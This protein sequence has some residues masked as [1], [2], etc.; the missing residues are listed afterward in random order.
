MPP[1]WPTLLL[2]AFEKNKRS[3]SRRCFVC[4]ITEHN[5]VSLA[6]SWLAQRA[7]VAFE[8]IDSS[9]I[10]RGAE[11]FLRDPGRRGFRCCSY[12]V[13]S[14]K[15]CSHVCA[16]VPGHVKSLQL[17]GDSPSQWASENQNNGIRKAGAKKCTSGPKAAQPI[18]DSRYS[19]YSTPQ[20]LPKQRRN[21]RESSRLVAQ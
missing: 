19:R 1:S 5:R 17:L 7:A 10:V 8:W 2:A 21:C 6:G 18:V 4:S 13:V 9:G 16:A 20:T 12:R 14:C 11:A 3:T 15:N